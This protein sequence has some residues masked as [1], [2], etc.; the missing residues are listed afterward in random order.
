MFLKFLVCDCVFESFVA[1]SLS[2]TCLFTEFGKWFSLVKCVDLLACASL[3]KALQVCA[4]LHQAAQVCTNLHKA[5]LVCASLHQAVPGC[6][7]LH[8]FLSGCTSLCKS[9]QVCALLHKFVQVCTSLCQAVQ[10][11]ASL[12]LALQV[13][14]VCTSVADQ[15]GMLH[16]GKVQHFESKQIKWF[17]F[18]SCQFTKKLQKNSSKQ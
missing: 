10:V 13:H 12:H 5:L 16:W 6:A 1:S 14:A 11:C 2:F 15:G 4:S 17:A 8:K 3:H 18:Q 7:S 9:V